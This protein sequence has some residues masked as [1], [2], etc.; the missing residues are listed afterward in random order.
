MLSMLSEKGRPMKVVDG[1]KFYRDKDLKNAIKWRCSQKGCKSYIHTD[2]TGNNLIEHNDEHG[3]HL[4]PQNLQREMLSNSIKVEAK[5]DLKVR[6]SQSARQQIPNLP[7]D[8]KDDVTTDDLDRIRVNSYRARR[9]RFPAIP[10]SMDEVHEALNALDP[11][12]IETSRSEEFLM[13]NDRGRNIIVFSTPSN[14]R[15]LAGCRKILMDG[16]F[17]Y[18]VKHF[19]QMFTIHAVENKHYIPLVYALLPDKT[20]ETYHALFDIVREECFLA[21][22]TF[23]PAEVAVDFEMGIHTA[24][25]E[26][27]PGVTIIGCRFHLTQSWYRYIQKC[28]MSLY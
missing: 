10:K 27:F 20:K 11:R 18:C 23:D 13:R 5:K 1:F 14:L 22:T 19:K 12:E 26:C 8:L 28:G 2:I 6:P 4:R 25:R 16:T 17:E 7:P 15:F 9:S 24:L 3:G 21:D